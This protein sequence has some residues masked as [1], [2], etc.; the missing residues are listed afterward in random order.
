MPRGD[1]PHQ[2]VGAREEQHLLGLGAGAHRLAPGG[3]AVGRR[4]Q[5]AVAIGFLDGL[6]QQDVPQVVLAHPSILPDPM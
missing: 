1:A 6:H 5:R 2:G 3:G 4:Q